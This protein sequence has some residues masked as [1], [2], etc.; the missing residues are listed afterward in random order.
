VKLPRRRP[1]SADAP[2]GDRDRQ[3]GWQ[4]ASLLLDYPRQESIDRLPLLR[5]AA[6]TLPAVMGEPLLA[7]LAHVEAT[8]LSRLAADYVETF[9]LKRRCCLYLTYYAYGDTRKRGLAILR[10]KHAYTAAGFSVTDAELPDHLAVVLEFAATADLAAGTRLLHERRAGIE[11]LRMSLHEAG[12]AYGL[13]LDAVCAALPPMA[14]RDRAEVERLAREGPP[15]EE[16]G[17]DPYALD[18]SL[19]PAPGGSR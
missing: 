1:T 2:P 17:L 7:F 6:A 8:P 18:P 12:S 16:V 11:L 10:I 13:V 15:D 4:A 5:D 19:M 14:T 3:V 9:D